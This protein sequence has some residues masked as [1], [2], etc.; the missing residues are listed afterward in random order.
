M[1]YNYYRASDN[2]LLAEMGHRVAN[3]RIAQ[4]MTQQQLADFISVEVLTIKRIENGK[5]FTVL[6]LLKVLRALNRLEAI[7]DF[8]PAIEVNPL[9]KHKSTPKRVRLNNTEKKA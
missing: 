7:G 2:E 5:N 4:R 6:I 1:K 8:L 3:E 9:K